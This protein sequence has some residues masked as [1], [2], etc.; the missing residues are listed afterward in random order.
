[1]WEIITGFSF[2]G[3]I[4]FPFSL[5][6]YSAGLWQRGINFKVISEEGACSP[7]L[8]VPI[9]LYMGKLISIFRELYWYWFSHKCAWKWGVVQHDQHFHPYRK[10]G[11]A[12]VYMENQLQF[13]WSMYLY[14]S[15][16]CWALPLL[17][18]SVLTY[19]T[20]G[21]FFCSLKQI[22][23]IAILFCHIFKSI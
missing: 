2:N 8:F 22:C 12:A 23:Y 14:P 10:W 16:P 6:V 9:S 20:P 4:L 5:S 15:L 21:N 7:H 17:S 13:E 18:I 11:A 1:M 3:A 19:W